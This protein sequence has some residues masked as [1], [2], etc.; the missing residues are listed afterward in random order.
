M[1]L[2]VQKNVRLN[3]ALCPK[4]AGFTGTRF[5]YTVVPTELVFTASNGATLSLHD[6]WNRRQSTKFNGTPYII[7]YAAARVFY[8]RA[9]GRVPAEY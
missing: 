1:L 4:T 6:M 9:H 2:R 8:R 7:Q 5:S 3:F